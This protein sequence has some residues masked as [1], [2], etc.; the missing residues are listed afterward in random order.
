MSFR[1]SGTRAES[2]VR[3]TAKDSY[4]SSPCKGQRIPRFA[5]NDIMAPRKGSSPP[6]EPAEADALS[7]YR[8]K[9]SPDRTP[10]PFSGVSASSGRS[11]VVHK[12]AARNM[13]FDLRLEVDGVL[14][15]WAVPKRPSYD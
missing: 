12:H 2:V 11:F 13:H 4:R 6:P 15:S 3:C 5:R 10:E 1:A 8:A 9:R 7:A 14:A